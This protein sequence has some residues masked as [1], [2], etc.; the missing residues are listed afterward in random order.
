M[1][2]LFLV[3]TDKGNNALGQEDMAVTPHREYKRLGATPAARQSA[4]RQLFRA[5]I[6]NRTLDEIREATNKAWTLGNEQF[7]LRI[8]KQID[9][10]VRSS[11]HG[12]DRKSELYQKTR[13]LTP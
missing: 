3:L 6:P 10:P 9:R 13:S 7:Q 1:A 2:L 4:Y 11:G 5:R 12:G 8:E